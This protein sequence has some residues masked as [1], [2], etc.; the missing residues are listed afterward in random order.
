M[1]K[2]IVDIKH[3]QKAKIIEIEGGEVLQAR[4]NSIGIR[5]GKSVKKISSHFLKGPQTIE[6][7]QTRI[8]IGYNMAKKIIVEIKE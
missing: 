2:N 5:L 1:K 8:A 3:G 7:G 6:V 4:L